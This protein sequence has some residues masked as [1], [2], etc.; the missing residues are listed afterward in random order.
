MQFFALKMQFLGA[1]AC[2]FVNCAVFLQQNLQQIPLRYVK[3]S[4]TLATMI[5]LKAVETNISFEKG[6]EKWAYVMKPELYGQLNATKVIAEAALRSGIAKGAI[7][8]AWDALSEVIRAW[9]TEGHS[10]A[11]PGVGTMRFGVRSVSVADVNMVG[12]SL[13][14]SRRV[15]FT[16]S[17]EIKDELAKTS[18]SITCIDRDGNVVKRVTSAD[19]GNVDNESTDPSNPDEPSTGDQGGGAG[20]P[21]GAGGSSGGSSDS[22]FD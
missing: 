9:A 2:I 1:G 12:S 10:V 13:I 15:V 22:S 17:V 14:T 6:K 7:S 11:V 20:N 8:A 4:K 18:V 5:K 16:P 3:P 21:G 19:S